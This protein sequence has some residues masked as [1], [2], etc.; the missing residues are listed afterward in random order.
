VRGG[1]YGVVRPSLGDEHPFLGPGTAHELRA[2]PSAVGLVDSEGVARR[3]ATAD[4]LPPEESEAH[5]SF[6]FLDTNVGVNRV[7]GRD[8]SSTKATF[9]DSRYRHGWP[10]PS[11]HILTAS[12]LYIIRL[13]KS[14]FSQE[15]CP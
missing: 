9:Y 4:R 7:A 8:T 15:F 11:M 14:I 13:N 2:R 5:G 3:S 1:V 6:P 10:P 12:N